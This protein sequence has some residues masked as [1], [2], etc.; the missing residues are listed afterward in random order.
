M[1]I[2]SDGVFNPIMFEPSNAWWRGSYFPGPHELNSAFSPGSSAGDNATI[3]PMFR[4][5]FAHPSSRLPMPFANDLSTDEWQSAHVTPTLFSAPDS[6][7]PTTPT[8]E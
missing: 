1:T 7:L 2:G 5:V 6:T 3:A 4:S 8:T